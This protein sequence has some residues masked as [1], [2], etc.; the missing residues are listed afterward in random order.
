[1]SITSINLSTSPFMGSCDST[2]AQMASKQM[3]QALTHPNCEIPYVISDEYRNLVETSDLGILIAKDN[4]KVYFNNNDIMIIFYYKLKDIEVKHIPLYKRTSGI[5]SSKLRF[6][7][8]QGTEFKKGDVVFS[9]DNF[10]N[11]V[12][13]FGYNTMTGYFNFFGFNEAP[14]VG[15]NI[16]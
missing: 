10:K 12:P 13:S 16:W 1:M 3:N 7:L 5:F 4:G 14:F 6:S 9:Y 8:P 2:R 11:G 15:N